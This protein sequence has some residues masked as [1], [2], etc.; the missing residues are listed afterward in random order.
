MPN[1]TEQDFAQKQQQEEHH[2]KPLTEWM[3][4]D[5]THERSRNWYIIAS[6]IVVLLLV[7]SI[8][9]SNFLFALIIIMTVVVYYIQIVRPPEAVPFAIY[10]DG[11]EIGH[12]FIKWKEI[13]KFWILYDPPEV[14]KIYFAFKSAVRPFLSVPL[15]NQNPI[16]LRK[17]LTKHLQEDLS[18][19]EEPASEQWEKMLKL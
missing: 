18:Q 19:E 5:I 1:E 7:Y 14:K 10:D 13:S 17:I 6:V 12:R 15:E 16:E 8:F 4:R 9:T 11:I 3:I 2:A